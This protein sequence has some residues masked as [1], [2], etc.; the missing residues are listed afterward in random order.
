[1]SSTQRSRAIAA[2]VSLVALLAVAAVLSNVLTGPGGETAATGVG[3]PAAAANLQVSSAD[4]LVGR[5]SDQAPAPW[6]RRWRWH[7]VTKPVV[8]APPST[9]VTL[10]PAVPTTPPPA[11]QA[12][13][14][15]RAVVTVPAQSAS[16]AA[17]TVKPSPPP[18]VMSPSSGSVATTGPSSTT[19][20][21]KPTTTTTAPASTAT[22]ATSPPSSS[23]VAT[24]PPPATGGMTGV[25]LEI[26]R[27]TN[28]LRTNPY[29]PLARKKGIP[30]CL[31]VDASGKIPAV[32]ALT[33]S[34]AV[35]VNMAR[36][37][38]ADM[39]SRN[40]MDHRPQDSSLAIYTQLGISPRTYGENVAWFQGYS[41]AQAAQ[42]FFEGWRESDGHYC[43][44]MSPNYTSFGVGVYKGS[45]RS[46]ATQNFY[47]TR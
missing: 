13:T 2:L 16:T 6:T 45:S 8:T 7:K 5:S 14:T 46:W 18:T 1:M 31:K 23:T 3:T 34:E 42:V 30:S 38:S 47:A 24:Q 28:E 33:V 40:T 11:A 19:T 12:S 41:D 37:W 44:M 15:T 17:Q 21:A 22:S 27:M 4:Q 10:P 35:S 25:E 26:A 9:A 43:N 32:P 29:G 39:N 20:T 36:A